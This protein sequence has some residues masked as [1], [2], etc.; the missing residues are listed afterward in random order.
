[1]S[2]K[3]SVIVPIYGVESFIRQCV[4]SLCAQDYDYYELVFVDDGS[5]DRSMD[6]LF[7]VLEAHPDVKGKSLIIRQENAGLPKARMTG[8]R[9]ATGDYVIHVDSD[10]WVEPDYLSQLARMAVEE[11][12]DVVYCDYFKE[13]DGKPA[14]VEVE[15]DFTPVDGPS[16]VKAVNNGVIRAYMWNKLIRRELYDLDNMIVPIRGYHEDI[17]FQTQILCPAAKCV[18]LR[19]PLYHYRRRRSGSLTRAS[20]V[21]SRHYS[22]ENMLYLYERLPKDRE[23]VTSSG[24]YI[25]LRA[26]WYCCVTLWFKK[27]AEHPDVVD[28]LADMEYVRG[29]RV[30]VAK[31]AYTKL[32]CKL[33]RLL[34]RKD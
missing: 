24:I 32:C 18:H 14:K 10:D 20:L 28:I 6:I 8:L 9:A 26:G 30:P 5:K 7:E 17:V 22:A 15:K 25:L 29:C 11:E 34:S 23:P 33:I 3:V 4:E 21:N 12:A 2:P 1:M 13:Y 19:K 16:A 27:L 31:Q